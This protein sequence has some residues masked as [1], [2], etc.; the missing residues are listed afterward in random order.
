MET[1]TTT[2]AVRSR[3]PSV[4]STASGE[5]DRWWET[6]TIAPRAAEDGGDDEDDGKEQ[7]DEGGHGAHGK[8][9]VHFT[10]RDEY[11][12]ILPYDDARLQ[13]M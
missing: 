5:G 11:K 12:S 7:E 13:L 10:W 3:T 4:D 1:T 9:V 6:E 8:H 2:R